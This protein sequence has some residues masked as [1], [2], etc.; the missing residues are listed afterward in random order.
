MIAETQVLILA[1]TGLVFAVVSMGILGRKETHKGDVTPGS[2]GHFAFNNYGSG[3]NA[4]YESPSEKEIPTSEKKVPRHAADKVVDIIRHH[5]TPP[6]GEVDA[7]MLEYEKK[8]GS[9][10][11]YDPE[12]VRTAIE[13]I[14]IKKEYTLHSDSSP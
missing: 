14:L 7:F 2:H 13:T 1:A 3:D 12:K 9:E 5:Y 10:P 8:H 6:K 11:D 4:G